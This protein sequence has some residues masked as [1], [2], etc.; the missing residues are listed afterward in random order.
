MEAIDGI[1]NGVAQYDGS[2][3]YESHT[4]LSAR[5][6]ALNPSWNETAPAEGPGSLDARFVTAM[7]L[8][9]G[10][11]A[12]AVARAGKGWLPAREHVVAA[13]DGAEKVHPSGA[14]LRLPQFC[15]WKARQSLSFCYASGVV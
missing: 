1:D 15:P 9:G 7:A 11:F 5:V 10:E 2:A 13:L 14:V 4:H 12:A 8:T 6:G 3:R